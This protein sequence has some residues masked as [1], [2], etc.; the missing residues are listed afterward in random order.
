MGTIDRLR[1]R[2]AQAQARLRAAE[3][4]EREQGRKRQTHAH[5]V[6]GA[7]LLARPEAFGLSA[8]AVRAALDRAVERDHDRRALGLPVRGDAA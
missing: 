2:A 4:R 7:L 8:D 5:I 6:A 1:E 3:A